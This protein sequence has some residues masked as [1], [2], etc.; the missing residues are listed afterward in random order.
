MTIF[1][2][3][4]YFEIEPAL[5]QASDV[6]FSIINFMAAI[7]MGMVSPGSILLTISHAHE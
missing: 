6:T 5:P 7:V 4:D 3:G 2:K 1:D